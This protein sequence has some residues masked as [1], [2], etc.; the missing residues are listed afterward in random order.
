VL[1]PLLLLFCLDGML[2]FALL[3]LLFGPLI[4]PSI[5]LDANMHELKMLP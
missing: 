3:L 2:T 5:T 1:L 4:D